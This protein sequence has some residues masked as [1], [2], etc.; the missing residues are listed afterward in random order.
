MIRPHYITPPIE[1]ATACE[2]CRA[3]KKLDGWRFCSFCLSESQSQTIAARKRRSK[4]GRQVIGGPRVTN[5]TADCD[6]D[7]Q[8]GGM[9]RCVRNLEDRTT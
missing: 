2:K 5:S 1:L 7:E 6:H 8:I 3:N 9:S 4:E